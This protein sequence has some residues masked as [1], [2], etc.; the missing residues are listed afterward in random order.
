MTGY[1][2]M[3]TDPS[4]ARQIITLTTAHVGNTGCNLEDMESNQSLGSRLV[5]RDCAI[6]HSNYRARAIFPDWLK[7]NGMVAIAGIDTVIL[8]YHLRDHGAIGAC[9]ST[10]VDEP[11][12]S[13]RKAKAFSGLHGVDLALEVSRQTIE[14]WHEGQ[15]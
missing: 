8:R 5:M 1:Q 13:I 15:W 4:Y 9:I 10:D 7:K 3:L 11:R 6:L 14:R 12:K 2:E